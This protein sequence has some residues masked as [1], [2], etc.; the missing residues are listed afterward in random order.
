MN[1]H[2]LFRSLNGS[3]FAWNRSLLSNPRS[4]KQYTHDVL[5]RSCAFG[6]AITK[7]YS[8]PGPKSEDILHNFSGKSANIHWTSIDFHCQSLYEPLTKNWN[9]RSGEKTIT[10][11]FSP[12]GSPMRKYANRD[13]SCDHA[14]FVFVKKSPD[15]RSREIRG[16][17]RPRVPDFT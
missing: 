3:P 14:I 9:S 4:F 5:P 6:S 16:R 12:R 7:A 10:C 15:R 11:F 13:L 17:G 2:L 1:I 8:S